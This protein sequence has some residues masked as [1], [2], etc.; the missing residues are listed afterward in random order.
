MLEKSL[1]VT[2]VTELRAILLMEVDLNTTNK[3]V[4]GN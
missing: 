3:I 4:H 1:Q 2:Q